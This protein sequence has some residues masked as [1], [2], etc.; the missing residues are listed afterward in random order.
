MEKGFKIEAT[1]AQDLAELYAALMEEFETKSGIP[2][3][4]MNRTLL[5]TGMIH[6]L[7][8]M[9]GLGLIEK[10]KAE[11]LEA[12][13]DRVARDTILWELLQMVRN[14]WKDCAG[15]NTGL[16]DFKA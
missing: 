11:K 10:E 4:D 8:M 9:N 1:M 14:Y 13:I 12:I 6:H 15:G 16:I 2:L 3:A 7:S 5:Q